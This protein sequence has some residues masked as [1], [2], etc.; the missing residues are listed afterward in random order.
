M[1]YLSIAPFFNFSS[2]STSENDLK[3]LDVATEQAIELQEQEA[4]TN[5]VE[6]LI[7]KP[8]EKESDDDDDE[9]SKTPK[10]LT[11]RIKQ[12]AVV[13]VL[14]AATIGTSYAFGPANVLTTYVGTA[15]GS[16]TKGA[17]LSMP[18]AI[19]YTVLT[20]ALGASIAVDLLLKPSVP[21]I[22]LASM[23]FIPTLKKEIK[24]FTS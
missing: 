6:A 3:N 16:A 20:T 22:P 9:I 15:F 13:V 17:T 19:R 8:I 5:D 1:S 2:I 11:D 18:P 12:G 21:Y 14:G 4:Q 7:L 10:T 23:A 24:T